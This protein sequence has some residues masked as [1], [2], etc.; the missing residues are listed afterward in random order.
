M[1][2]CFLENLDRAHKGEEYKGTEEHHKRAANPE[3]IVSNHNSSRKNCVY[4]LLKRLD[5]F[6]TENQAA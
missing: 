5:T 1:L 3:I 2:K 6:V 4:V